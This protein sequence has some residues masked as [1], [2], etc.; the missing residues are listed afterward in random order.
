MCQ[1]SLWCFLR[2]NRLSWSSMSLLKN[3]SIYNIIINICR[4]SKQ[5]HDGTWQYYICNLLDWFIHCPRR[6]RYPWKSL[7]RF[8]ENFS[9][10]SKSNRFK[11]TPDWLHIVADRNGTDFFRDGVDLKSCSS[12]GSNYKLHRRVL[13]ATRYIRSLSNKILALRSPAFI[14]LWFFQEVVVPLSSSQS[15]MN[16]TV[17]EST[18]LISISAL[19]GTLTFV[20][21][22]E[23]LGNVT[24]TK[25]RIVKRPIC[26]SAV[27]PFTAI[28]R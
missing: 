9:N 13:S 4:M 1:V 23:E 5:T 7:K 18:R 24:C 8:S 26:S 3:C 27:I 15:N 10:C 22:E 25:T 20:D 17:I 16:N 12:R 19:P 21:E 14:F 28:L 2:H 11:S 6:P